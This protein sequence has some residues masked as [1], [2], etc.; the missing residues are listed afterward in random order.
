LLNAARLLDSP[1]RTA[2]AAV[3]VVTKTLNRIIDVAVLGT[4]ASET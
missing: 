3:P 2:G 1:D 4:P